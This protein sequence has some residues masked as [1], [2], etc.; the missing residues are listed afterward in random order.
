MEETKRLYPIK[1]CTIQDEYEWGREEFKL[2]DLGY[3]DSLVREGW[4]AGNSIGEVMDTYIDR[5]TGDNTYEY[6]G[7]QFPICVR[8][9]TIKGDLPLQVHPGDEIASQRY[10]FLGKE[11]L[12][13][14]I[15]PGKDARILAGFKD[16]CDASEF[17]T[18]CESDKTDEMMNMVAPYPG[19]ALLIPSG[20]PHAASGDIEILE[21]AESSP[22]DFCLNGR[23]HMVSEDEFDP[24]LSLVDALD[25]IKFD[26]FKSEPAKADTLADIPAFTVTR[27]RLT[28]PLRCNN[29][30][31]DSFIIYSC[32]SGAASVQIQVLGQTADFPVKAGETMLIPAECQDFTIVPTAENT[33]IIETTSNRTEVDEYIDP[34]VSAKLPEDE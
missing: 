3:K 5:I 16:H 10:D 23:G 29:S 17:F 11:K 14:V 2:A 22:L 20:T 28:D 21:I 7:R 26:K 15:R 13:Y 8:H 12:W 18:A 32:I 24:Q 27:M 6:Y 30:E 33:V 19:L 25:F 31:Y 4:L 34:N 9:L 1:F